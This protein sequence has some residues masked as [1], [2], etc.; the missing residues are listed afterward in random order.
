V[1]LANAG[2]DTINSIKAAHEFGLTKSGQKLAGLLVFLTDIHSLG[3]E[4][5][6]GLLLSES[7]Y[8]DRD[9]KT[10]AWSKKF[11]EK[12]GGKMPTMVQAGVYASVVHYLKAL[13]EL[14]SDADGKAVVDEMKKLPTDDVLFG[15][16]SIRADGRKIHSFYLYEVKKPAESKGEWDLYKL[17]KEVPGDQAFRPLSEGGCSMVS[18][19][20]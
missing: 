8:W 9:A 3:L 6:Q 13:K 4:T 20:K 11:A 19:A 12:N 16:G 7:F 17:V 2:G 18:A 10:R 5:A 1:G 15:K 14:K